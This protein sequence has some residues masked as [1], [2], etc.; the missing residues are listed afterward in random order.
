MTEITALLGIQQVKKANKILHDRRMM[1]EL[2]DKLLINTPSL[3]LQKIPV[4]VKSSYYKYMVY[5]NRSIRDKV[6]K[7]MDKNFGIMLPG[8]VYNTLCHSQPVLKKNK[9][10]VIKNGDQFFKNA[11]KISSEQLCLPLYPG[12]KAKE[13]KYV[14][15]S[16]KK[17]LKELI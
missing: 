9:N 15:H 13:I 6:K 5:V 3:K 17:T 10:S 14:V 1:A 4:K 2:Y 16:L 11:K 12:L 8:E 7:K